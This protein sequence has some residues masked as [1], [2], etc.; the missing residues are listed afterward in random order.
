MEEWHRSAQFSDNNNNT[1]GFTM[2][3][4]TLQGGVKVK[5][6]CGSIIGIYEKDGMQHVKFKDW[7]GELSIP[8]HGSSSNDKRG[9]DS[10]EEVEVQEDQ[11]LTVAEIM[12]KNNKPGA[13]TGMATNASTF[14][15]KARGQSAAAS[16][17]VKVE[18]NKKE[19]PIIIKQEPGAA[20]AK[21]PPA[22][23]Q[24]AAKIKANAAITPICSSLLTGKG[25]RKA[26]VTAAN[27]SKTTITNMLIM[28]REEVPSSDGQKP[29]KTDKSSKKKEV[30]SSGSDNSSLWSEVSSSS[31]SS[32][33][34]HGDLVRY[35]EKIAK[36]RAKKRAKQKAR[37][38]EQ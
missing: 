8:T 31:S 14:A 28:E 23:A 33:S 24:S 4:M 16:A 27:T 22:G 19:K 10:D 1:N 2:A 26:A 5:F 32:S 13:F 12:Q 11:Q 37:G 21:N 34:D 17:T 38:K 25:K 35:S 9:S 15:N 30:L 29:L 7:E 3:E 6:T 20:G 18:V 36:K